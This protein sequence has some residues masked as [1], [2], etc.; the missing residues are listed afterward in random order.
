MVWESTY[1][2][3]W[4]EAQNDIYNKASNISNISLLSLW[5]PFILYFLGRA[6]SSSLS[7]LKFGELICVSNKR[8]NLI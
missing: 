2:I 1:D 5:L 4:K 6:N 3:K 7:L 8:T